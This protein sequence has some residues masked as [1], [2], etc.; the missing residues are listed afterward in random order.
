[1]NTRTFISHLC[2]AALVASASVDAVAQHVNVY[3]DSSIREDSIEIEGWDLSDFEVEIPAFVKLQSN[4]IDY[5]GA[6]WSNLHSRIEECERIPFSIVHI[7]DS[8][9][10]ADISTGYVRS[11]LQF[12]YGDAGRGL[13]TPFRLNHTNEP[14][15]YFFRS[16][17]SWSTIKFMSASWSREMGFTGVSLA[18]SQSSIKEITVGSKVSD[19]YSTFSDITLFHSGSIV[20]ASVK[21]DDGKVIDSPVTEYSSGFTRIRLPKHTGSVSISFSTGGGFLLFGAHLSGDRPGLFYN[22]I[23]NNGATY[24]TYNRINKIGQGVALMKP[25]LVIISLGTNEAFGKVNQGGLNDNINRLVTKIRQ[26]SPNA[27]LLLVTPMECQRKGS[28]N[29]NVKTVRN[30]IVQ[31]GKK[32]NIAVYDWY[33]IAGGDRASE[34]WVR[35]GLYGRDRI[36]HTVKGYRVQGF[37]LYAALTN[38]LRKINNN[39]EN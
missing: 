35:E 29:H 25:D 37:M 3:D 12:D 34:K 28:I 27:Q 1:M 19:S 6:D 32:H 22:V 5:N 23:G 21:L 36:H 30:V 38:A 33:E 26:S 9:L 18:P 16:N 20:V 11:Q 31:Y 14:V 2:F 39:S 17:N 13:V 7:G 4:Q 10:Q 8:H 15:D 24:Y